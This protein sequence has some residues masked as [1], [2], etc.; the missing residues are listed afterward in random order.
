MKVKM[1][2][3]QM[4]DRMLVLSGLKETGKLGYAIARNRRKIEAEV[5]E[6]SKLRSDALVKFGKPI[7]GTNKYR[8]EGEDLIKY[9]DEIA[10]YKDIACEVDVMLVS[11][12]ELYAGNL[13]SD[14]MYALEWMVED[15]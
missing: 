12:D 10:Q 15:K 6:Y 7:E 2:N 8:L 14:Q 13:D 9:N 4:Y 3:E 11:P 5:T 1:K